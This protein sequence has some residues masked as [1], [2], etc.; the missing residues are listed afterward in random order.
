ME[1]EQVFESLDV[2]GEGLSASLCHGKLGIGLTADELFL[3]SDVAV[4]FQT[5]G[6]AGEVAV[7]DLQQRL[8]GGEVGGAVCHEDGHDA[9]PHLVLKRFVQTVDV[10]H[11]SKI[12]FRTILYIGYRRG[13]EALRSRGTR[14]AERDE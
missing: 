3:A 5:A 13:H 9:Q 8:Q 12:S 7:C 2:E 14:K 10:S 1:F 4:L 6:M 11:I